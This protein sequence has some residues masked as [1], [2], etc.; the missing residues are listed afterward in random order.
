MTKILVLR[1]L[2]RYGWKEQAEYIKH[3]L[4][5]DRLDDH[6]TMLGKDDD[7]FKGGR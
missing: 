4:D 7:P 1:L 2:R 6:M 5:K 3:Q